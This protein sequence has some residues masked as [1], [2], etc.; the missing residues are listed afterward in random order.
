MEGETDP[1]FSDLTVTFSDKSQKVHKCY[2]YRYSGWFK[3]ALD[4]DFKVCQ[5][6]SKPS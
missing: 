3:T 2:L 1:R 4:S 6:A 5:S